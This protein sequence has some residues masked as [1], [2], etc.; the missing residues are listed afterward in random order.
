MFEL[1]RAVAGPVFVTAR[2]ALKRTSVVTVAE[3]FPVFGSVVVVDAVAVFVTVCP[4]SDRVAVLTVITNVA[5]APA[6]R[7]EIEHDT[8][9]PKPTAGL[10]Q[11]NAGPLV[12]VSETKVH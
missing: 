2:S 8:R 5:E 1:F 6:A 4:F 9:P 12:C 7:V 11:L 10:T 3:L